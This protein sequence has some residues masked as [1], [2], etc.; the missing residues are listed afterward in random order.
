MLKT[1]LRIVQQ[2]ADAPNLTEAL[3]VMVQ[4]V[5][6][7][8]DTQACTI[9]LLEPTKQ[10]YILVATAGLNPNAVGQVTIGLDQGL[11]GLVGKRGEPINLADASTHKKFHYVAGIGEEQYKA[12][13]GV[14]II[15]QRKLLGVL[16]VQQEEPRRFDEEEEAFLITLAT[17]LGSVIAHGETAGTI[18]ALLNTAPQNLQE[19][20]LTGIASAPGVA[21]GTAVIVYPPADLDAVPDREPDDIEAEIQHFS[22]ALKATQEEITLLSQRLAH[23]LS[24]DEQSLFDVYLRILDGNSLGAEVNAIIRAGNWAQGALREVIQKRLRQFA[25]MEDQYLR[26]RAADIEDLGRRVLANLQESQ[27]RIIEYPE[28]TI[29]IGDEVTASALAEVPEGRL[30]GVVSRKGANYSH[31]AILARALDVPTVMGV[32]N[33]PLA[34]V[35]GCETIVD[36]FNGQVYLS[37]S[38]TIRAEYTALVREERELDEDLEA[39]RDEAAETCDGHLIPLYVNTG[40]MSDLGYSLKAG[41]D[42]VGLYRT[43]VPFMVRDR[44]PSEEEQR[45]IYRQLLNV[46]APRPVTM[47]TLDIGGDKALPYFPIVEDNPFLGWR[48]IRITLDH[49]EVFLVQARAMLRA[50]E[51]L[52]NLRI[53]LPMVSTVSEVDD[54]LRLLQQAYEEVLE[55][56]ANII[57]PPVGVMVEVPSAVYQSQLLAKRVDFLSV[58]SNDLTQYLLA[59]DRNNAR[60]AGLYNSLHPVV[61]YALMQVVDGAHREG[62]EASICGEL[63]SDPLAVVL[64]VA[65]GFDTLSMSAPN[66]SRVKMVLKHF[67]LQQARELLTEVLKMEEPLAVR[68]FME[69]ALNKAGLANMIRSKKI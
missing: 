41:A 6:A 15:Y 46:F 38:A 54:A 16:I 59:V 30:V 13:L 3:S 25:A 26:E 36:G 34:H 24:P 21:I 47:R 65:M 2:V 1:L 50:S 67:T 52:H 4:Q 27:Q 10:Y 44:F 45:V 7:A 69:N 56:G 60:V 48:G 57:M 20:S 49:P 51:G 40:L 53:M 31:V 64:L 5:R 18:S 14:P 29:L 32:E 43:E 37:P 33:L 17:Q 39:L 22:E 68:L 8:I 35:D 61:L 63:A 66:L 55:E 58:G 23:N 12:F 9:F 42:G 62:K 11:I 28:Q 19:L